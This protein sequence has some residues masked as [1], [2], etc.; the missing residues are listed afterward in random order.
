M[1]EGLQTN[2]ADTPI[3]QDA[4][5]PPNGRLLST[6]FSGPIPPATEFEKYEA[7]LPGAA[8]RILKMAETQAQHRHSLE[9]FVVRASAF[10]SL[11]GTISAL[12]I[13]LAGFAGGVY[14]ILNGFSVQGFVAL[15]GP[16]AAI[17]GAFLY[18]ER[19]QGNAETN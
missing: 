3:K 12:I 8:D 11:V 6:S 17:V 2:G 13:V 18:R 4:P 15:F 16:L 7:V 1:T 5:Q 14:L 19:G 10:S 9:S